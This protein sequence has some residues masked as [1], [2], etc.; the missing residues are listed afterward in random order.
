MI[1][2]ALTIHQASFEHD[3]NLIDESIQMVKQETKQSNL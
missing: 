3:L 1:I 2:I